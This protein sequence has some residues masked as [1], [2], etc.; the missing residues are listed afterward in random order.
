MLARQARLWLGQRDP[1]DLDV[2]PGS[3]VDRERAPAAADV[4]DALTRR[5]RE[6]RA[7][8]LELRLL[9]LL[10]RLRATREDRAR[11]GHRAIEEQLEELVRDVVM[12]AYRAG[13]AT[14]RGRRPR[15][16]NSDAGRRG[17]RTR[18]I[19]LTPAAISRRRRRISIS[20]TCH[21]STSRIA[22]SRSSTSRAPVTYA[23]PIPSSPGDRS[24]CAIA[25]GDLIRKVGPSPLLDGT[26]V[27]SHS[28][29]W[30]GRCGSASRIAA[31]SGSVVPNMTAA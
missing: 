1:D 6:L 22:A 8:E 13:V 29:S 26:R 5:Q 3:R 20:G 30:K 11:V 28:A 7:N 24:T 4:E 16:T 14:Q 9:R 27:P 23:R 18:P 12:V 17:G 19:A 2:V 15:R 25:R 31:R 21:S 10:E